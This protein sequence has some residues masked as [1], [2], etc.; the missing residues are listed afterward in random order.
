ME[1]L[2]HTEAWNHGIKYW[3]LRETSLKQKVNALGESYVDSESFVEQMGE[4]KQLHQNK[5]G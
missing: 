1:K 5:S 3:L 4:E 2:Q